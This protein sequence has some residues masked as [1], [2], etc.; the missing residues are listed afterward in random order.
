MGTRGFTYI[1]DSTVLSPGRGLILGVAM[2]GF[3]LFL[4]V[5]CVEQQSAIVIIIV[6]NLSDFN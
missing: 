4:L 1:F 2:G 5:K 3:H 6:N